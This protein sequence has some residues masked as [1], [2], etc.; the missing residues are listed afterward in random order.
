MKTNTDRRKL[1]QETAEFF[2]L[3]N[4]CVSKDKICKYY[5]EGKAGCAIGRLIED[6]E[7]CKRLDEQGLNN[8]S[9]PHIWNQLPSDIQEY[10]Q[11]F[12]IHLQIFHDNPG[13]WTETGLSDRGK[14]QLSELLSLYPE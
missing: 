7:L 2:T 4:R 11:D 3:K 5:I 1:L 6:K 12:L 10:G 8:V 9:E 13:F 14:Y